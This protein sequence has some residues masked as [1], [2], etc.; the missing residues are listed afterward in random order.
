MNKFLQFSVRFWRPVLAALVIALLSYLLFF[1]NLTN[2]LPG[3]ADREVAAFGSA[4][5]LR[6]IIDDPLNA[7]YKLVL[8]AALYL[9]HHSLL[10]TRITAALFA[11]GAAALFFV[12]ARHW[13]RYRIAL[14]ATLMF[15]SSAGFLHL[16]RLGSPLVLQMSILLLVTVLI[17][18]RHAESN[19]LLGYGMVAMLAVL[20]YVPGMIWLELLTALFLFKPLRRSIV[21]LPLTARL[22]YISLFL[23]LLLP[24]VRAIVLEPSVALGFAGL[25]AHF[26]PSLQILHN[27]G[28]ALLAVGLYSH[29][30]PDLWLGHLPLLNVIE[31]VLLLLGAYVLGRRLAW[32]WGWYLLAAAALC[33][34]LTALGGPVGT[35]G[36]LPLLYL[37]MAAGLYELLRR[38]LYVFP[39]NPFARFTGVFFIVL[40]VSFSVLYHYRAYFIAWPHNNATREAFTHQRV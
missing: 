1:H 26:A 23:V 4:A 7:P 31:L 36:L 27:L 11:A 34:L 9:G 19:R 14:L 15:A 2:L 39:R 18:R 8:Y 13:F 35:S 22:I 12:V 17:W 32:T 6:A 29:G 33:V 24:L 40:L 16:A 25:P 21:R 3:Y 38:W 37:I 28:N 10:T 30:Q 20:W 5:N